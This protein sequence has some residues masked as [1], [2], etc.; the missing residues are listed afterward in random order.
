MC[1]LFLQAFITV[2]ILIGT[3]VTYCVSYYVGYWHAQGLFFHL[4]YVD[5]SQWMK[6][7]STF[8]P[9]MLQSHSLVSYFVVLLP[10]A[11]LLR[12]SSHFT[13]TLHKSIFVTSICYCDRVSWLSLD[14]I[15]EEVQCWCSGQQRE[16][17]KELVRRELKKRDDDFF[18]RGIM[19]TAAIPSFFPPFPLTV[20]IFGE[21]LSFCGFCQLCFPS[22]DAME[23][24]SGTLKTLGTFFQDAMSQYLRGGV[25]HVSLTYYILT[26]TVSVSVSVVLL[27]IHRLVWIH[28]SFIIYIHAYIILYR[29]MCLE[30]EKYVS[31]H[32]IK[33][34]NFSHKEN[35][36]SVSKNCVHFSN[37]YFKYR[38]SRWQMHK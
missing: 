13:L 9:L 6:C 11:L 15:P 37:L 4:M 34:L 29:F 35:V 1:F 20:I 25:S 10:S 5:V 2:Y 18:K 32:K 3:I 26:F 36:F 33:M 7:R 16:E 19:I 21:P 17:V 31:L 8:T 14:S 24:Q 27:V 38:A 28:S 30:Q 12:A 22:T 23:C